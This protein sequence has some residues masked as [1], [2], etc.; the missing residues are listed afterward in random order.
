M[1]WGYWLKSLERRAT[2]RFIEPNRVLRRLQPLR[3]WSLEQHEVVEQVFAGDTRTLCAHGAGVPRR[4]PVA[5]DGGSSSNQRDRPDRPIDFGPNSGPNAGHTGASNWP[6][7]SEKGHSGDYRVAERLGS[8]P[9][10]P[11]AFSEPLVSCGLRPS[12]HRGQGQC[13][14]CKMQLNGHS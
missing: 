7:P 14:L 1:S 12:D 4:V 3:R 13:E 10:S 5:L 11:P 2:K 6:F 8:S 9:I